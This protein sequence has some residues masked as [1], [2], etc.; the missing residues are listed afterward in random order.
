MKPGSLGNSLI[1]LAGVFVGLLAVSPPVNAAGTVALLCD[2]IGDPLPNSP[3]LIV[4]YDHSTIMVRY[5]T[6]KVASWETF[7]AEITNDR[8][9]WTCPQ[10]EET[11]SGAK[12]RDVLD[13]NAGLFTSYNSDGSI[14]FTEHCTVQHQERF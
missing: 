3:S 6:D 9:T 12:E 10:V 4:D 11:P 13:R 2:R 8:I 7:P 1:A 14:H 5:S